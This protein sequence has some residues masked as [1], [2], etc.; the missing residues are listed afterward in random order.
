MLVIVQNSTFESAQKPTTS[1]IYVPAMLPSQYYIQT[2]YPV[3]H[4]MVGKIGKD[5]ETTERY[6][7]EMFDLC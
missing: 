3:N 6:L 4:I 1:E 5:H 7:V 2:V